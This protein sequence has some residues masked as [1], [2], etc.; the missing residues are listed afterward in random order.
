MKHWINRFMQK[1]FTNMI[2]WKVTKI[3][4]KDSPWIEVTIS[5][6]NILSVMTWQYVIKSINTYVLLDKSFSSY[7]IFEPISKELYDY[8]NKN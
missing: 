7:S 1:Y 4:V 6:W 2:T 3:D 8:F 5:N